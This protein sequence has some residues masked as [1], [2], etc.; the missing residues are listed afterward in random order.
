MQ[1]KT[2][3]Y[4][5]PELKV[6]VKEGEKHLWGKFSEHHYM[7]HSLP[8]SCTF[9]TFYWM[10]DNKEILVGCSGILFQIAKNTSARR[11]TRVVVLPEYQGLGFGS[12]IINTLGSY[13]RQEGIEKI[14][15]NTFHPRLGEY[16]RS[17]DKWAP[18]LNNLKEFKT[19]EVA[20]TKGM[21][22]LRDG[23]KMYRYNFVGCSKY[24]LLYNPIKILKTKALIRDLD[25]T[26]ED[27]EKLHK[28]Y[29][30]ELR[31]LSPDKIPAFNYKARTL[32]LT[33]EQKQKEREEHKR[34]FHRPKR[35]ILTREERD[36]IKK[37]RRDAKNTENTK[38]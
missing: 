21:S 14:F 9:Y 23:V 38:N 24:S 1:I 30:K 13:Y 26:S 18:S 37:E 22:G 29:M 25:K 3:T 4:T 15:L 19:S 36:A 17:S 28:K 16:L 31:N 34:L 11:F 10:K 33:E 6:L 7:D 27:Y 5:K 32:E 35:K 8:N 2:G 12:L 20:N